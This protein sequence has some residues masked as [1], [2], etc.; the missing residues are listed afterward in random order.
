MSQEVIKPKTQVEIDVQIEALKAIRPKVKPYS[1]FGDDNLAKLDAQVKILEEDLDSDDVWD[2]WP[3]E[4]GDIEI[5]MSADG[6]ISW[7]D[8]ESDIEDLATDWPLIEND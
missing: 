4:E 5:R 7:R 1:Y 8:G 3:D 6:A 2:E